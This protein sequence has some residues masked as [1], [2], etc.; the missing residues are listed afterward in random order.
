MIVRD[1]KRAAFC[2]VPLL[3][4]LLLSASLWRSHP[5]YLRSH[6]GALLGDSPDA[7][8]RLHRKPTLTPNETHNEIYSLSQGDGKYFEIRFG[9]DV[10]NPNIIPHQKFNNS[11][12]IVGQLWNDPHK[13]LLDKAFK[14]SACVAQFINGVLMCIDYMRDLS[15]QPTPGGKCEGDIS[16]FSL[17]VG[18]HDA[19]VF[20]GPQNP[21]TIYGSNSGFT[22]FGQWIQDFR[23]LVG[24]DHELMT[25]DDFQS[26]T[27]IQRPAPYFPVEKNY[28]LFWDEHDEMHVHYD[29][30]P[31][32][33]FSKLERDGKAGEDLAAATAE[34]D[35]KCMQRYLPKL[36]PKLESIHQAT[37]SLKITL[38]ERA[39]K[40]C[41]PNDANTFI[42]AIIQH[43]TFY[44]WHSEYEPYVVLFRQRAPFELYAISKRPLW[45]HGRRRYQGRRTDMFYV[46]SVNWMDR[47]VNYHGFLDDAVVL[48]FGIEDQFSG[49]IDV[50]AKDLLVGMGFCDEE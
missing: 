35:Q 19:R 36:P 26:G 15:I 1:L 42:L 18:P 40:G 12:Y 20:F 27:E 8:R 34:Q 9:S 47:G 24:W 43:K 17:N 31:K 41:K 13:N 49:G 30:Y 39:D 4:L 14:E 32:R 3:V 23:Q 5:E 38:C 11:W 6:V 50:L 25:N 33:G 22:C 2:V 7:T 28:F 21:F 29:M 37:N 48:G 44:D 46:T 10:Y 16:Y 45:I